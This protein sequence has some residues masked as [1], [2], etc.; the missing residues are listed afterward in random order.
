MSNGND[1][2]HMDRAMDVAI[3]L[4]FV[5]FIVY[6]CGKIF[7]PF[8]L[9]VLWGA[10]IAVALYPLFLKL[11]K[12]LGDRNRT[13]GILFIVISLTLVIAPTAVLTESLIDGASSVKEKLDEGTLTVPPPNESVK[14]WPVIGGRTYG[15]WLKASQNL[16]DQSSKYTEQVKSFASWL[17]GTIAALGGVIVQT[18]ISLIIA[19]VFMMNAIGGGRVAYAFADR[20]GGDGARE[21]VTISIATVRS[22]VRGVLLVAII[23]SL[24][25]AV[26]L[27]FA[28]V[29]AVGLWAA[30]VLMLAI[31]Q[32]PPIIILGPIAAY[33]FASND[34]T[35]VAIVFL[36]WS[37][38][39][40]GA[41]GFLKPIFLGRGVA[42]P[43]LIILVGAIGGMIAAGIIGL[44][45]GAVILSLGYKLTQSWLG[46]S[47]GEGETV[48]AVQSQGE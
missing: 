38:V 9:P 40:S 30:I 19:G 39:V 24:M 31:V 28:G 26:G 10:I 17:A 34:S 18:I 4:T 33:V 42:V 46:E 15:A 20:V 41:D 5:G 7:A 37:L 35:A 12:S 44:F 14:E 22:V 16:G 1:T 48:A 23:Q 32:L 29:P 11:K 13:A 43:M 36:I 21:L 6:W 25:A 2:G 27:W 45:L 8:F 3:R 47:I